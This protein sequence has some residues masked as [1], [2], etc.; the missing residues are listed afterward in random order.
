MAVLVPE[1]SMH[2]DNFVCARENEIW[3]PWKVFPVQTEAVPES[4][5]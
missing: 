2:E 5:H 1:T 3:A 4:M